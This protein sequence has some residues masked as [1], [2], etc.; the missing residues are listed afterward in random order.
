[1]TGIKPTLHLSYSGLLRGMVEGY[2]P[3]NKD[4]YFF[5]TSDWVL[6][7]EGPDE[8]RIRSALHIP[9]EKYFRRLMPAATTLAEVLS[10]AQEQGRGVF[11]ESRPADTTMGKL[12]DMHGCL[13]E[14][15]ELVVNNGL[16]KV[17]AEPYKGLELE[18]GGRYNYPTVAQLYGNQVKVLF[19]PHQYK[20]KSEE[21]MKDLALDAV[22]S[23]GPEDV[24]LLRVIFDFFKYLS[25]AFGC[26]D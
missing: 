10:Q 14:L 1:M 24:P 5:V 12:W 11:C 13:E 22:A 4:L 8:E 19:S 3:G 6:F 15:G 16:D 17:S 18:D 25:E 7:K 26:D 21:G 20:K 2:T 23:G 9:N